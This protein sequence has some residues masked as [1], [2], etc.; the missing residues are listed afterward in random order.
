MLA[1]GA[2][3]FDRP[4]DMQVAKGLLETCVYMYRST[5]TGLAPEVW[6]LPSQ[7]VP[8]NPLTYKRTEEELLSA[9][10]WWHNDAVE[11]PEYHEMDNNV[12]GFSGL[13]PPVA[14]PPGL[15]ATASQYLL[16]PGSSTYLHSSITLKCVYTYLKF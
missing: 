3:I 2:K 5:S 8:Y 9:H 11:V 15:R 14:R 4:D 13:K 1:M 6:R 16:R 10:D 12:E 7:V